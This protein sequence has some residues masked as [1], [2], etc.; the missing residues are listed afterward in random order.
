MAIEKFITDEIG[1]QSTYFRIV[2]DVTNYDLMQRTVVLACYADQ[3]YR[4]AEKAEMQT[5]LDGIARYYELIEKE[6]LTEEETDEFQ[7]I[8]IQ[9]L[10]A[11][12]Y[13][14][15][16]IYHLSYGFS[17]TDSDIR[18]NLYVSLKDVP[19]FDGAEDV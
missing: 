8:D 14:D 16:S 4:D 15:R 11:M 18:D 10:E 9:E 12:K 1:R 19:C 3:S 17:I 5:N 13:N 7:G 6:I 2:S